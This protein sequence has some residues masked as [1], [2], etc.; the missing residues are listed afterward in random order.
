VLN[1]GIGT[2]VV[3]VY[4]LPLLS[5]SRNFWRAYDTYLYLGS[6]R[7]S[8]IAHGLNASLFI[9]SPYL[10]VFNPYY[11]FYGGPLFTIL[12]FLTD[13][14]GHHVVLA[15]VALTIAGVVSSYGGTYWVGRQ[16][17]LRSTLAHIPAVAVLSSAYWI[18]VLYARTDWPEFMAVA[19]IPTLIASTTELVRARNWRFWPAVALVA[20][21]VVFTG[22]HTISLLWGTIVLVAASAVL[23][24]V[25]PRFR[26][27][28]RQLAKVAGLGLAAVAINGW[29]LIPDAVYGTLT[30]L[31]ARPIARSGMAL[32]FD[33]PRVLFD[34]IRTVPTQSTTFELC[35]QLPMWFLA[36]AVVVGLV[37]ALKSRFTDLRR[38]LLALEVVFCGIVALIIS[39]AP[40]TDLPKPFLDIQFPYRLDTYAV[41]AVAGIVIV[42]LLAFQRMLQ[43]RGPGRAVAGAALFV[44]TAVSALLAANQLGV[45]R[46]H[47]IAS[48]TGNSGFSPREALAGWTANDDYAD[49]TS[50]V[51]NVPPS[52]RKLVLSPRAVN[53][54]GNR[55]DEI[56]AAPPGTRPFATNI[57]AGPGLVS[58]SGGV[59][60]VG[61]TR[62]GF[63]VVR[64]VHAGSRPVRI[65]VQTAGTTAVQAGVA[66]SLAGLGASGLA[67][68]AVGAAQL[69]RRPRR[70]GRRDGELGGTDRP[71]RDEEPPATTGAVS[72]EPE[73]P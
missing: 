72:Q 44:L 20:S 58:I 40:V 41:L 65:V 3:L 42:A 8:E 14:L 48:F 57:A 22:S 39:G 4:A 9:S 69:R 25:W 64:R 55:L 32:F 50:P 66:L 26:A 38:P 51:V 62:T 16:C 37:I 27:A 17:G 45:T 70:P 30:H 59:V 49:A 7:A 36:W 28:P 56:V 73:D 68:V 61:R 34:G 31:G 6:V 23:S 53:E 54:A 19:A 15:F 1:A 5:A 11:A 67:L 10:G 60:R 71:D 13:V 2:V 18:T 35:V 46:D 43:S 63:A 12:G 47:V 52:R 29:A 24:V 21:A 33:T